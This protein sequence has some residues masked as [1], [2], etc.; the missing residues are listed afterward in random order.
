MLGSQGPEGSRVKGAWTLA[1]DWSSSSLC[2]S[3]HPAAP[4]MTVLS[5]M[6][7]STRPPVGG[8]H[9]PRSHEGAAALMPRPLLENFTPGV[10]LRHE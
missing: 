3:T 4:K 5:L 8:T 9:A 10:A 1:H 7:T 6:A 2:I